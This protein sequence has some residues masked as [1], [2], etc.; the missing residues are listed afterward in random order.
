MAVLEVLYTYGSLYKVTTDMSLGCRKYLSDE[1]VHKSFIMIVLEKE[2][3]SAVP[4]ELALIHLSP[5]TIK[6]TYKGHCT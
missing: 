5:L 6:G 1:I 2:A 4:D 3:Y